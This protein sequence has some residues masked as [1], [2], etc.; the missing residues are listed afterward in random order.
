VLQFAQIWDDLLV[1]APASIVFV[2]V[3]RYPVRGLSLGMST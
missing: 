2:I 1:G 3:Q